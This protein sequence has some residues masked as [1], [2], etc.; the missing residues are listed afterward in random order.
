MFSIPDILPTLTNHMCQ[1]SANDG[2]GLVKTVLQAEFHVTLACVN[3]NG[4]SIQRWNL[5]RKVIQDS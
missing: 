1:W 4:L 5:C 3:L 2:T